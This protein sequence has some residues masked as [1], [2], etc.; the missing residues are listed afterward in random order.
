MLHLKTY[1]WCSFITNEIYS[2][3]DPQAHTNIIEDTTSKTAGSDGTMMLYG[4]SDSIHYIYI[5]R[6][7]AYSWRH[8]PHKTTRNMF[9]F[10]AL[11]DPPSLC[12]SGVKA[13][14]KTKCPSGWRTSES[15]GSMTTWVTTSRQASSS[16]EKRL[17]RA[18]NFCQLLWELAHTH[19]P[20]YTNLHR[21]Q[22]TKLWERQHCGKTVCAPMLQSQELR[23]HAGPMAHTET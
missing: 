13:N 7:H 11:W 9:R 3:W 23:P 18:P 22:D 17:R 12:I 15:I 8:D 1:I 6:R 21:L 16:I 14:R 2:A 19:T 4:G 20:I 5:Y 10:Q